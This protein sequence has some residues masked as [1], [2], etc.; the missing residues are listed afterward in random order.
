MIKKETLKNEPISHRIKIVILWIGVMF[1]YI[2][3]DIKA[4]FET[5][6]IEQIIQGDLSGIIVNES[7]LFY[8]AILMSVPSIMIF[9]TSVLKP[10]TNRILNSTIATLLIILAISIL[11]GP[12]E[13]W[14]YYFWYTAMEVIFLIL[15]V[16]FA[17]RWPKE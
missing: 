5:G 14:I 7:F 11:F 1:F 9:L 10:K 13:K 3:A 6:F 2:Y 8:S 4:F 16:I 17:I 15:I 12:G